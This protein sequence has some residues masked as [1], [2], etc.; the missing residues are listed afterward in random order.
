MTVHDRPAPGNSGGPELLPQGHRIGPW[1]V[2]EPIGAG[3]W[4]TVYAGRAAD[5]TTDR[6]TDGPADEADPAADR[7]T[8]PADG[9]EVALK[10]MPT[11][12]LAP[13]Q[14]RSVAEAARREIDLSRRAGHPRLVR[15]LDS[16]VLSAPDQPS[17]DHA[18]VLVMERARC[19]LRE[20]LA[21]GITE[22][23]GTRLVTG[24]VEGLAH[25]H[26]SGW[27]HTDLKPE[28][29]LIGRDG[30]VR[31]SD[32]GLAIELTGTHG[33]SGPMGTLDYLPPERW[34]EPL[35]E[36]GVQVRTSADIW[37]FGVI[38]HEVF[39]HGALPFPGATPTARRAAVQ[40]YA[41]GGAPL[42]MDSAVPAFWRALAADCLA[43]S[44]TARAPHTA[45]HLLER[46]RAHEA[47]LPTR[48]PGPRIRLRDRLRDRSGAR[49]RARALVLALTGCAAAAALWA[50]AVR[51]E[52][53]QDPAAF[54]DL[55]E[56]PARVRV[57]NAERD[58]QDRRDRDLRCS[59]GLAID[60]R[61]PYTTENVVDTRVWHGDILT[62]ECRLA[63]GLPILDE[64]DRR[65]TVWFRIRVPGT[66]VLATAW[67]PAV[68]TKDHP[69]LPDCGPP[70]SSEPRAAGRHS[71]RGQRGRPSEAAHSTAGSSRTTHTDALS[72]TAP[73]TYAAARARHVT[74][75]FRATPGAHRP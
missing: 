61:R 42:R 48:R 43:P 53:G 22:D 39:A 52:T 29:I 40:E 66:K 75:R 62:A 50:Y 49:L 31:L 15:L 35:A 71:P 8:H 7:P 16:L 58:C 68:R 65:S 74:M 46:V 6:A 18:I 3:G 14:A 32:F 37:A 70:Q 33:W 72:L 2:G 12:G 19:S 55:P 38:V 25:L 47:G 67:L 51:K 1:V 69:A 56:N 36:R 63:S 60:P 17:F 28:N 73:Q 64:E 27:V 20:L 11:A 13:R 21:T 23:E 44:H 24:I 10:V 34:R 45:E 54:H 4:A 57:F 26:R 30:K 41:A 59:L 9:D 5:R